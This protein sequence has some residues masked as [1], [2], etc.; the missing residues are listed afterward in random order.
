MF[1]VYIDGGC[2]GN[3]FQDKSKRIMISV[4]TDVDGVVLMEEQDSGGSNNIAEF[5]ALYLALKYAKD[6]NLKEI[7]V[8]SDSR[9]TGHW[10]N[11]KEFLPKRL[12]K[13]NDS[14]K[15]LKIHK[16]V[17]KLKEKIELELW[18]SPREK[19]LAGHYIEKK[20][21]SE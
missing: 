16:Q 2:R 21:K 12:A 10:N 7:R 15:V 19:N 18:W 4:V 1:T 20:Q 6:N 11:T 13:M 14:Q 8:I 9:N 5:Q 3:Q 17:Q